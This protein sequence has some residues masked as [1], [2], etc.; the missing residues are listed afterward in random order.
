MISISELAAELGL[1][2]HGLKR[3]ADRLGMP[4]RYA[5]HDERRQRVLWTP[6]VDALTR[7]YAGSIT[8]DDAADWLPVTEA[9]RLLR[10]TE[11][12]LTDNVREG[13]LPIRRRRTVGLSR[14]PWRYHPD[15][16]RRAAS[17]LPVAP[18]TPPRGAFTPPQLAALLGCDAGTVRRWARQGCPSGQLLRGGS[19]LRPAE[20][21]AWLE[22]RS[23]NMPR[24]CQ[25]AHRANLRAYLAGQRAA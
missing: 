6:E 16:V 19:Y 11:S 17:A 5:T 7:L 23:L 10:M 20:V 12:G 21:L 4:R 9:A 8:A 2:S 13:R 18:L 25:M 22:T 24:P 14:G 15:D 1:S 3:R